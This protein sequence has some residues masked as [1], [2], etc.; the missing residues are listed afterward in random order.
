MLVLWTDEK[1]PEKVI[2]SSYVKEI[3][4]KLW[5]DAI[6]W[7]TL[8]AIFYAMQVIALCLHIAYVDY[9]EIN[10]F[11]FPLLILFLTASTIYNLSE[12]YMEGLRYL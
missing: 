5:K 6:L 9:D 12:I 1:T 11:L 4:E 2:T 8:M 3:T 7:I 10:E